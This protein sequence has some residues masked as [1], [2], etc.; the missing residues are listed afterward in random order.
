[1][2]C[3]LCDAT[4]GDATLAGCDRLIG[5]QGRFGVATCPR[6]GAGVTVPRLAGASLAQHYP[7]E[8]RLHGQPDG[9]LARAVSWAREYRS[10][11]STRRPPLGALLRARAV[12]QALDVGCGRGDLAAAIGRRGWRVQ[13]LD[14]STEAV[15]GA[16]RQGVDARVGTAE[17]LPADFVGYDLVLFNHSLEHSADPVGDLARVRERLHPGGAVVISVPDWGSWHRRRFGSR[18]FHLDLP[19]HLQH[20]DEPSLR[21]AC[22]RAGLT[23]ESTLGSISLVGFVGSLQYAVFGRCIFRGRAHRAGLAIAGGLYPL[24]A[25]VGR[26]RGRDTITVIARA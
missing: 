3:P 23:V 6:C 4:L 25:L 10:D 13:G 24:T 9:F 19:R 2:T 7:S 8:Y 20:F 5:V 12:G 21:H 26:W 15:A 14:P 17:A 22:D 11:E 1:M 16:R 18:W